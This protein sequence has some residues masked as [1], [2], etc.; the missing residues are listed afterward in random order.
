MAESSTTAYD[1]DEVGTAKDYHRL[2]T[3]IIYVEAIPQVL[4]VA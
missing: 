3:F 2:L 1:G 4:D